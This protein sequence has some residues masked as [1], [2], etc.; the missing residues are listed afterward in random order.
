[1]E[2]RKETVLKIPCPQNVHQSREFLGSA[3]YCRL[4]IPGFAEI[5]RPLY[6]ATKEKQEFTWTETMENSFTR[7]K[8]ALLSAPALGLPDLTKPFYLYI[9]E[10]K[11]VAKGV[12]IQY[13]GP[14]KRPIAYFSKWL[15]TVTAGWPP[16]LR[17]IAAVAT[18]VKDADKLTLGQEL[19]VITPHAIEGV[20]KQ[21]PDRWISNARL[22][23]YQ[24]LL[25][26]PARILF[27]TPASLNPVTLL[28]DPDWEAP[29]HDCGEILAH[30][31]GVRTDLRDQPLAEADATWYTDGN[32]FMQDGVRYAG[33]AVTTETETVWAEPL[34]PGTS[35]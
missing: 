32:S 14:W 27:Q 31:H 6:E 29:L 19:S 3:G 21:P 11:E 1:M 25:L 4:W 17:I 18:M 30:V 16:C 13:I 9:D 5:A 7:L 12:L 26:N 34:A 35:A 22:T 33:V 8:Q 20:L 23:H 10:S 2:A 15:D 28:P 24:G